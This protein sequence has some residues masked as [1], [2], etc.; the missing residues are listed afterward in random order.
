MKLLTSNSRGITLIALIITVIIML[1]LVGVSVTI[2]INGGLFDITK[3]AAKRTEKAKKAEQELSSERI[4]IDEI[5]YDSFEDY[6]NGK[7]SA[8]QGV[9]DLDETNTTFTYN[10]KGWTNGQVKVSINTTH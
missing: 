4:K 8:I 6:V 3:K 7:E 2:V 9:E 1:I 5:W 10:P